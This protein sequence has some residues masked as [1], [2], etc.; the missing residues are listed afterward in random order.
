MTEVMLEKQIQHTFS[1]ID[2]PHLCV[3]SSILTTWHKTGY[4]STSP[5]TFSADC[6]ID[7]EE[8]WN[9]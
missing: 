5:F 7:K 2:L 4:Q 3:V 9:V 1:S 6:S 8:M